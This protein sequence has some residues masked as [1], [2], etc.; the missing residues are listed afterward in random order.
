[1]PRRCITVDLGGTRAIVCG[2][3]P[4]AKTCACGA[5]GEFACD[6][7]IGKTRSGKAKTCD[8]PIC[9][10]HGLEVAPDRHLCPEHQ[11]AYAEWLDRHP[12]LL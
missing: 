11:R 3:F 10:E 9:K 5:A 6:W 7:K 1:M 2:T 8:K 12:R 4:A